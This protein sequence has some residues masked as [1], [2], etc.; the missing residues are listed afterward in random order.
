MSWIALTLLAALMQAIRT[1]GQK[2]LSDTVSPITATMV[3]YAFGLP[4]AML[5]LWFVMTQLPSHDPGSLTF[6]ARFYSYALAASVMQIVATAFLIEVFKTRNFAVGTAYAKTEVM[7]TAVLAVVLFAEHLSLL[8]W[9]SVLGGVAG[10]IIISLSSASL[11]LLGQLQHRAAVLGLLSGLCFSLT[12]LFLRQASLSLD[13]PAFLTAAITLVFMVIVQTIITLVWIAVRDPAQFA[14]LRAHLRICFFV[15][16]T[17]VAGSIGW[18][19]AMTLQNPAYVK[20]LGQ[21][22]FLITLIITGRVFKESISR[23]E[24]LGMFLV[25]ASVCLL[26]LEQY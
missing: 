11:N 3:R 4:F 1:A 13:G 9:I 5:Y 8:A 26:L 21:V 12:S 25:V 16:V 20:A 18:F 24:G 19:T 2:S 17:S 22:E 15:G 7:M 6:T 10:V 23:T 14:K